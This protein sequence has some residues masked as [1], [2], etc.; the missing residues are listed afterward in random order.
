VARSKQG[1]SVQEAEIEGLGIVKAGQKVR[2]PTFGHGV[3][4]SFFLY[5][6]GPTTVWVDFP[7]HGRKAL[8]PKY[9]S[10]QLVE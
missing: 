9:A 10:L 3:I 2:H 4:E 5:D 7:S 8:L 6:E 1:R